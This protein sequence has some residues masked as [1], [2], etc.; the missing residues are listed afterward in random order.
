MAVYLS[1]CPFLGLFV[2][3]LTGSHKCHWLELCK[4][5]KKITGSSTLIPINFE[6]DPNYYLDTKKKIKYLDFPINLVFSL[7][8]FGKSEIRF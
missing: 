2:N 4:K 1:V 7:F 8:Y 3:L 5:N 6:N